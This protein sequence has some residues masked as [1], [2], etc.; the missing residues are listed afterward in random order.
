MIPPQTLSLFIH[1]SLQ[2]LQCGFQD[3]VALNDGRGVGERKMSKERVE[4][5]HPMHSC[6]ERSGEGQLESGVQRIITAQRKKETVIL[7]LGAGVRVPV[8]SRI[9]SS[10]N[11]PDRL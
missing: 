2:I 5:H 4:S 7:L 6:Y 3:H 9:F 10:L 11:R 8:G 1:I